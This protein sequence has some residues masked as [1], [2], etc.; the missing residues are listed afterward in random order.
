VD[1]YLFALAGWLPYHGVD[2]AE[3]PVVAEHYRR[4]SERPSVIRALA[5]ETA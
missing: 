2:V 1:A 5:A 3:F 4:M